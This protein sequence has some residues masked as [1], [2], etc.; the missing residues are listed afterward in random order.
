MT[1]GC[2]AGI[3]PAITIAISVAT[4]VTRQQNSNFWASQYKSPVLHDGRATRSYDFKH[5][6]RIV[7]DLRLFRLRRISWR[8]WTTQKRLRF[9]CNTSSVS[10]MCCT[11]VVQHKFTSGGVLRPILLK[12]LAA[13][14][15]ATRRQHRRRVEGIYERGNC[16][17]SSV[18][19]PHSPQQYLLSR[20]HAQAHQEGG[21][22]GK[23]DVS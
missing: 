18:H 22:E 6:R 5:L 14:L 10:Q 1:L 2:N 11:T 19:L 13:S 8:L 21:Q 7:G 3:T 17:S 23:E 15:P 16:N 4:D 20:R 9:I 12:R